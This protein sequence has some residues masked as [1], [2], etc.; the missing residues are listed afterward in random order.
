MLQISRTFTSWK[1]ESLYP[2]H[3][4]LPFPLPPA[5]GNHASTF[6]YFLIAISGSRKKPHFPDNSDKSPRIVPLEWPGVGQQPP[7]KWP[8][9]QGWV[10]AQ[11]VL[12]AEGARI[13]GKENQRTPQR[14]QWEDQA[15]RQQAPLCLDPGW[16]RAY[17]YLHDLS[18]KQVYLNSPPNS[19]KPL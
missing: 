4:A 13:P 3:T 8:E 17:C 6:C 15:V 9:S 12:T 16:F 19:F 7:N 14:E 18:S 5:P 1:M 11:E 2:L 10:A